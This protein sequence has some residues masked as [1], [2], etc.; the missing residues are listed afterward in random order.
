MNR[1]IDSIQSI[2]DNVMKMAD[3]EPDILAVYL[4]GSAR[5][6]Y[7]RQDS[8]IDLGIML[9]PGKKISSLKRTELANKLSY[10]LRRTVDMG[11]VSSGN[12]VYAREAML[13]GDILY[14]KDLDKT[15]LYR[16]N[17]LGMYIQFNQ[18]RQEVVHAYRA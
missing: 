3:K 5:N 9:E 17:L 16:A 2:K 11:V 7:L 14:Q 12:L 1:K 15:N 18:D 8:D 4:L 6:G 13:K 10:E